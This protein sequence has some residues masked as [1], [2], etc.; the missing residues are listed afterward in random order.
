MNLTLPLTPAEEAKLLA[1]ARDQGITPEVLVRHA[2]EPIIDAVPENRPEKPHRHISEVI[3]ENM[4]DVPPEDLAK[5]PKD[6][7]AEHDHYIYGLPKK[8]Q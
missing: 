5:L 8:N 3:R 1:K 6:G 2:L 7:A 4:R